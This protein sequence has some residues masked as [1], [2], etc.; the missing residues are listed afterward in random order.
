MPKWRGQPPQGS[1]KRRQG[2]RLIE[3]MGGIV[4]E[5]RETLLDRWRQSERAFGEMKQDTQEKDHATQE[6]G[7][8]EKETD[9]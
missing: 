7:K 9:A 8:E 1:W 2:R 4:D 3:S 5:I 6:K